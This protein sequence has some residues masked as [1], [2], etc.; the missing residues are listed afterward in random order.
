MIPLRRRGFLQQCV[1]PGKPVCWSTRFGQKGTAPNATRSLCLGAFVVNHAIQRLPSTGAGLPQVQGHD[2]L[3]VAHVEYFSD[4]RR[5]RP[6]IPLSNLAFRV[7]GET[8]G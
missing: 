5:N 3:A 7:N 8:L 1:L 4:E 6:S 2:V